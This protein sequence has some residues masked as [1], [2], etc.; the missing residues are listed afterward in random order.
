VYHA[1]PADAVGDEFPGRLVWI[2]RLVFEGGKPDVRGPTCGA[3]A[4]P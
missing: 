1:W 3:Q 4:V 2:D